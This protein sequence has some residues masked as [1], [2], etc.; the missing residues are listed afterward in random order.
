MELLSSDRLL[1]VT[2]EEV[3]TAQSLHASMG[4][5]RKV[6]RS[7]YLRRD[8]KEHSDLKIA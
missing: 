5:V 8:L 6:I 7:T 4:W 2:S 1:K 3:Q